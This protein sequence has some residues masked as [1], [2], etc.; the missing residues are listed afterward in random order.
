MTASG[1]FDHAREVQS[2][3]VT[4]LGPGYWVLTPLETPAFTVLVNRGFVPQDRRDPA[5][6]PEG[7]VAGDVT[8]SGLLR[9]SEP[10]GGFLRANDPA[11]GRWYSRDVAA[12]AAAEG[13]R[14][15]VAPYFIDADSRAEPR[16]PAGRGTDGRAFPQR[17]PQ[18]CADLVR[19]RRRPRLA[20]ASR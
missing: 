19:P 1:R 11:G 3:A 8:V 18:L 6:R 14:G 4:E 12:I 16:R 7:A 15:P 20:G 17:P 10:G 9:L 13:L 5:S 2:L